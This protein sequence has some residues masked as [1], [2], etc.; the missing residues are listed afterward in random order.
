MRRRNGAKSSPSRR[1]CHQRLRPRSQ[2]RLRV[3]RHPQLPLHH[4][5]QCP[6][7]QLLHHQPVLFRVLFPPR[8]QPRRPVRRLDQLQPT[9][10]HLEMLLLLSLL[11]LL[12]K[13][14]PERLS[15]LLPSLAL[16]LL[17]LPPC[18]P[19]PRQPP[20]VRRPHLRCSRSQSRGPPLP[21]PPTHAQNASWASPAV[22]STRLISSTSGTPRAASTRLS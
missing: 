22:K 19:L 1:C 4:R 13:A 21:A 18:L 2:H 20:S 8:P 12:I 9:P 11:L 7:R 3:L 6:R 5:R 10:M 17:A 14:R 16:T 15:Q